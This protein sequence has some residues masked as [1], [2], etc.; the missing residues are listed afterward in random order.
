MSVSR[1]CGHSV[2][3][4][5]KAEG[6][7]HG[8][9]QRVRARAPYFLNDAEVKDRQFTVYTEARLCSFALSHAAWLLYTHRKKTRRFLF[10]I[11]LRSVVNA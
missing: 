5:K 3:A 8:V 2:L 9:Q 6:V 1:L 7:E 4:E 10:A 11:T